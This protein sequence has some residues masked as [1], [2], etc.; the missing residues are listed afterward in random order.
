[1]CIEGVV[2]S[3][4]RKQAAPAFN[5]MRMMPSGDRSRLE[6]QLTA[7]R[8]GT[9][10]QPVS[11]RAMLFIASSP[12]EVYSG[13]R[14]QCF[15][16]LSTLPCQ[17]NPGGF[18]SAAYFRGSGIRC[19]LSAD[20]PQAI[21]VIETGRWYGLGSF[22]DKV[23][24]HGNRLFE[25]Y[26]DPR[27]AEM[28][29]GVLLGEREQID[30]ERVETFM[31]TGTIHLLVI[32]GLH[33]GILAGA[34]FWL[35]RRMH[36]PRKWAAFSVG[37]TI[38]LYAFL[39]D[40]GP[41]VVRAT[42]LVLIACIALQLGLR[43]LGFNSLATAALV[44][45]AINPT[46]L[47]HVGAQLSFL[48]VAGL[49]WFAP[50]LL[51]LNAGHERDDDS[52]EHAGHWSLRVLRTVFYRLLQMILISATI[53]LLTMPLVMARFHLCTPIAV[54]VNAVVWLPMAMALISGFALLV[55]GGVSSLLATLC[56][57]LCNINLWTLEWCVATAR[58]IPLG[59]FWVSGPADWWL[60]GF[61]GG[62]GILAA[63]PKLR[64]RRVV[65]FTL[66]A[67]WIGI[68]FLPHALRSHPDQLDCTFVAVGHGGATI[69]ELPSGKTMLYDAGRFGNPTSGVQAISS[70]LWDHG[71]QR[72]DAVFLSHADAD[73]FNALPGLLERFAVQ[74]I[75]VSPGM[76]KDP[77]LFKD[78]S[79]AVVALLAA[80]ERA[81]VPIRELRAGDRLWENEACT[82]DVL[83]PPGNGIAGNTNANSLVLSV[84]YQNR[85]ILLPGDLESPGLQN[86]LATQPRHCEVLMAPH[87]GSRQS[88]SPELARWCTPRWVVFSDDGR[89]NLPEIDATYQATG[90]KTFHTNDS[91]AIQVQISSKGVFVS[92]FVAIP[93]RAQ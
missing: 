63:S 53:W 44:V 58:N 24:A 2:L 19:S 18:D 15:A 46:H 67:S 87:H 28:A 6:I 78:R 74:T 36:L 92:P 93:T 1:V 30:P 34:M 90:A 73:H 59:H 29:E 85:Q 40:S 35:V 17:W 76:F 16:K 23:R 72:L 75:F 33:L 11:G 39:V 41:P 80:I 8:D 47:F 48:S 50:R 83:H 77:Y 84:T 82:I 52:H 49:V 88:N 61:Y 7:L 71:I 27:C 81:Q 86:L 14:I 26:L 5:P 55:V 13:D 12:P 21:S 64:S 43:P 60:L 54:L 38:V 66:L 65:C 91:G 37:L 31:A 9:R 22:L 25:T 45:L 70:V 62:L 20:S 79:M 68:G 32:A 89:W 10:W 56:G 3:M 69:L 4:P 51:K 57:T 42:V